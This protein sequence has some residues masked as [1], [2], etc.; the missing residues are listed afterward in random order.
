V[1]FEDFAMPV[2]R[3]LRQV[4][5]IQNV[6]EKVMLKML[7]GLLSTVVFISAYPG[8]S[9]AQEKNVY[10]VVL[11]Q[12]NV[13]IPM[14]DGVKLATDIYRPAVN[15]VPVGEKFPML[16]QRTPYNKKDKTIVE[17]ALFFAKNGYVVAIQDLRGRYKSE[18]RFIKY[19]ND[20]K[21]GYDT[22][23]WLGK[24][25]T[26]ANGDVGM[27]GLSYGAHVQ[28]GAAKLNPPHLKTIVVNCGGTSNGWT[29][30]VGN[31][32]A[33]ELKQM[34]WAFN[35]IREETDNPAVKQMLE[36]EKIT[37]W[38]TVL[39]L[40]KGLSPL[41]IAPN[42]EDYAIEMT[43]HVNYDDYWKDLGTNWEEYYKQTSDIPMIHISGWYDGYALTALTNYLGLSRIKKSPV[44]LLMGPWLHGTTTQT[45][46]GDVEFGPD[47]AITD[48]YQEWHL[49]WYDHFLKGRMNGVEKEPAIKLFVMGTGDGHKDKNGRLYHGGS[50]RTEANWPLPQTKFTRYYLHS[51]GTLS[52]TPPSLTQR[53]TTY[54]FDP[55]HPVPT[56]G[57]STAA[58]KPAFAGGA[59]DQREKEYKGDPEQGFLGSKPPYLPLKSRS[60]VVIFQTEP[61][62]E[63]IEVTGPITVKLYA[64][65]TGLDTDFTA[66]LVDVYPPSTDYPSGYDM[67]ITDGII[68][69]RFRNSPEKQELMKAGEIYEF[70]IEP[71]GT[72]NVFKK[73]N[74]IRIDI[75]S[76]NF[77]RFDVNPNTGEP[78]GL[79][80][81][82]VK[83]DNSI[84][85]D[86]AHSSHV[87]L[88][89]ITRGK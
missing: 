56:I 60:D 4:K 22:V 11:H 80:R 78:L 14:R 71:Y 70:T 68:R 76:S 89:I 75:S 5:L 12:E 74:R 27:W 51:D 40:R 10:D 53:S 32:G 67:N 20:P 38:L 18:G 86:L 54:T 64:S 39:P 43:T 83:V 29:H 21:D 55:E 7:I 47:A 31:H 48:F 85:H 1:N 42:F 30:A 9:M 77:P 87:V 6:L 19:V 36:R 84:Y 34:I 17:Q 28:A 58:S 66:K 63:D 44:R 33:F 59:Y 3:E 15:G 79:S 49:R 57:A 37:D 24:N 52:P 65:S 50:W 16:L 88:P 25:V 41:S 69:A 82:K 61:L 8:P 45:F 35:Q 81:R 23:E 46:A 2:E 26:Y 62:K 73:G 72:G 13:M